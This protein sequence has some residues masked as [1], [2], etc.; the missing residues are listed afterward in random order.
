MERSAQDAIEEVLREAGRSPRIGLML[1]SAKIERAARDL[2]S[3]IGL[4]VSRRPVPL[5][6]LIRQLAQAEQLTF[7]DASSAE[8]LLKTK[9]LPPQHK[10][11]HVNIGQ[12][13]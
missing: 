12:Q 7:E 13:W 8:A 9:L 6:T 1:L 5:G 4:D 11:A 10:P 3:D 2:A